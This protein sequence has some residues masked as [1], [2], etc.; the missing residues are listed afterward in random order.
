[1]DIFSFNIFF[2][3]VFIFLTTIVRKPVIS[4]TVLIPA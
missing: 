4:F 1:M 2:F 3:A